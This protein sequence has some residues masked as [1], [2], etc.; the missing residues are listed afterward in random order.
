MR[1]FLALDLPEKVRDYL[2]KVESELNTGIAK[3][4]WVSKKN[5]HITLKFLGEIKE[6]KIPE[7]M[8]KLKDI[9]FPE[10]QCKLTEIG[11]FPGGSKMRVIWA[12][13]E[14]EDAIIRLQQRVDEILLK[15]FPQDQKF[16]AHITI[17][18]VRS[19]KKPE[20]FLKKLR[21]I[22]IQPIEFAVDTITLYKSDLKAHG[23]VY[24]PLQSIQ[25]SGH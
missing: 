17:G 15:M 4:A 24:T 18:R 7:I 9:K 13:L 12:G 21:S 5:I 19:I 10:Q 2:F 20:V 23:S 1:L 11:F 22:E 8:E 3:V 14:P 6:E 25:S 16:K